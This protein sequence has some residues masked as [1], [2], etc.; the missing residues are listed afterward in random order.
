[1]PI[2]VTDEQLD[3]NGFWTKPL[4]F[5][6]IPGPELVRYFD[7]NGYDLSPLEQLY[8]QVNSDVNKPHRHRYA[9]QRDWFTW[10]QHTGPHINHCLLFERKAYAGEARE[11]LLSWVKDAPWVSKLLA[12]RPKWGVD[13]SIDYVDT[14]GNVFEIFHYEWD[15]FV[16]ENVER[17]RK[18]VESIVLSQDWDAFAHELLARKS[19]WH[20]LEFFEQSK[21]KAALLNLPEERF[22][23]VLW[24]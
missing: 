15:D 6:F 22:K 5:N 9:L 11:Q 24:S 20:H 13:C 16:F 10:D 4:E 3:S 14:A 17:Q 23:T 7:A 12:I 21:W 18:I 19:E 2:Q 8:A 1:M